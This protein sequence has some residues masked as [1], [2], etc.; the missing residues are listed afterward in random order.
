MELIK[1]VVKQ[2]YLLIIM[3]G[4]VSFVTWMFFSNGLHGKES[5]FEGA[6]EVFTPVIDTGEIK[7]EGMDYVGEVISDYVPVITYTGG[8]QTEG[9]FVIFKNMFDVTLEE[10]SI[11]SGDAEDGFAIYLL[12]IKNSAGESAM[13][14]LSEEEIAVMEEIPA[15]FVYEKEQDILCCFNSG[16]YTVYVKIYGTN[17]GEDTY[18]FKLPV[19]TS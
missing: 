2:F 19:E 13:L 18:V 16:I 11:V 15:P 3:L 7:N 14:L 5:V 17:G 9:S 10:G 6:G 8:V 1:N 12:D 4:L